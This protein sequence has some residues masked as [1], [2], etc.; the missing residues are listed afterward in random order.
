MLAAE[1]DKQAERTSKLV[2]ELKLYDSQSVQFFEAKKK[3]LAKG[4]K[5]H[6]IANA[7]YSFSYDGKPNGPKS[8][9]EFNKYYAAN[10][11]EARAIANYILKNA[12]VADY[13]KAAAYKMAANYSLGVQSQWYYSA[14]S[15]YEMDYPVLTSLFL[16]I[17]S[18]IITIKY[19]LPDYFM[20]SGW[21]VVNI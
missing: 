18:V 17:V 16:T 20:M 3:L 14:L 1:V 9:N 15:L 13:R 6:E 2:Q 4:Y 21:A 10:P 12:R 19:N 5:E 7:L 8:S 11:V